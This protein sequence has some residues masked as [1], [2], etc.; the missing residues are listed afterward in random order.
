[1]RGS[2]QLLVGFAIA[3]VP[4][5]PAEPSALRVPSDYATINAAL[6]ASSPGD[7]VLVAPGVYDQYETRFQGCCWFSSVGFLRG[8]VALVSEGGSAGTVLRLDGAPPGGPVVLSAFGETGTAV[9]SGFTITGSADLIAI[10]FGFGDRLIVTDCVIRDISGGT[11]SGGVGSTKADLEVYRC[12]FENIVGGSGSALVQTSSTLILEDS[13][14]VNCRSGAI[15]LQYDDGFPHATGAVI[16]RCRFEDNLKTT[17]TGGAVFVS[18][19]DTVLVENCWFESNRSQGPS[20]SAGAL[21][22]GGNT[23]SVV[24]R[25]NTFVGNSVELGHGGALV[26]SGPNC[27]VTG[28]TFSGNGVGIDWPEGGAAVY[29]IGTVTLL[30]NA[31]A[32]SLGDEAV[33]RHPTAT[34][35]TGCNVFWENAVGNASFPLDPTD[36]QADPLFCDPDADDY[37][38][39]VASPCVPGNGHPACTELIGAW[40]PACGTVSLEPRSWG[41]LKSGYRDQSEVRR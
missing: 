31:I 2:G 29:L 15:V 25:N 24:V 10:D 41:S 13:E 16:R 12:Q 9:V 18:T 36:L 19:Y 37:R 33:G 1:M 38:V 30:N 5:R 27:V 28:N 3:C 39:S 8:G 6:D 26:V 11:G 40:E 34:I 20:S 7:S 14:F 32:G 23:S 21:G 22:A 4:L 35:E 17:G